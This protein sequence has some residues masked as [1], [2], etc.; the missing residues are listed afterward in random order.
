MAEVEP[1][2][3]S[4]DLQ[5]RADAL[6]KASEIN[7]LIAEL[8]LDA[9]SENVR[10]CLRSYQVGR[11]VAQIER[12]ILKN[13]KE[14]LC[15][16]GEF[17]RIPECAKFN[18]K[19][20]AHHIICRVQNLLPDVCGICSERYQIKLEETALLECAVC[21]QGVHAKCWYSLLNIDPVAI[22]S[23][24]ITVNDYV[25][26]SNLPGIHYLC[27]V[28]EER[29]I[30]SNTKQKNSTGVQPPHS[31]IN[32]TN[33]KYANSIV[34]DDATTA[35]LSSNSTCE[36]IETSDQN[37]IDNGKTIQD[38]GTD[39][40]YS[41]PVISNTD[42][43]DNTSNKPDASKS[44][45]E[46]VCRFFRRG[47]CKHGL[48]GTE[49]RYQHPQM[50]RKFTQ[51]GTRQPHGCNLGKSCKLFHPLMCLDSLRK[52]ECLDEKCT[53]QHIK[54]TRR[55]PKLIT[56]SISSQVAP[57]ARNDH[58]QAKDSNSAD[59][60]DP[61]LIPVN[62]CQPDH[63]LEVVRLLKAEILS[64]MNERLAS[65][66]AQIQN[67]QRPMGYPPNLLPYL[68]PP[69]QTNPQQMFTPLIPRGTHQAPL[70]QQTQGPRPLQI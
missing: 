42:S 38:S 57:P 8:C 49:C 45:V 35:N 21:G 60:S 29:T 18:K 27:T 12:D 48:R 53:Y 62:E 51:H 5:A 69:Q 14:I 24:N 31:T 1:S 28:C 54:G 68:P 67:I 7:D 55:Q 30:P 23:V 19:E 66:T 46:T 15:A 44:K 50:C 3:T 39:S 37:A 4:A 26:P 2:N 64:T 6:Q 13:K 22:G 33:D 17:L 41:A 47:T 16:T 43:I 52:S 9:P 10:S 34:V 36:G 25:N 70:Q 20:L 65:L 32:T 61:P 56:N 40:T 11:S 59:N 63:F 58:T